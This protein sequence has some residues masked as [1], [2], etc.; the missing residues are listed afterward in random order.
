MKKFILLL[1]ENPET[2][3]SFTENDFQKIF[4][5]HSAW[6]EKLAASGHLLGG[7]G[8]AEDGA[9]ISE[10]KAKVTHEPYVNGTMVGGYYLLQGENMKE[11]VEL[12]KECPC[13][14]WGGTTEVRAIM[15][16]EQ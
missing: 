6:S 14:L 13:H 1:H 2:L 16:Y 4:E 7:E 11:V 5:A 8:L 3:G 15:D 9:I 10:K 12:A